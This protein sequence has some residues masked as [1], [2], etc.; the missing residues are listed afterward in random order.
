MLQGQIHWR[1]SHCH[2]VNSYHF[3]CIM[4]QLSQYFLTHQYIIP[5]CYV[6]A[7]APV[8]AVLT[9]RQT[10][11]RCSISY[12][13]FCF[14]FSQFIFSI[15]CFFVSG[16]IQQSSK[17]TIQTILVDIKD[18]P[19][20][21]ADHFSMGPCRRCFSP[22]GGFSGNPPRLLGIRLGSFSPS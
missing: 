6:N 15:C 2:C 16:Q 13:W 18:F 5:Y 19:K 17:S 7:S 21:P 3:W 22:F 1:V 20:I 12:H 14:Q 10:K 4:L 11:V 8:L 9:V